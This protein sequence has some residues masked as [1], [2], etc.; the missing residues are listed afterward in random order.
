MKTFD[1][2]VVLFLWRVLWGEIE[3]AIPCLGTLIQVHT[4][5]L[6]LKC[7]LLRRLLTDVVR[8]GRLLVQSVDAV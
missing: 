3:I 4:A 5:Q 6:L 7:L 8:F 1:L 2:Q